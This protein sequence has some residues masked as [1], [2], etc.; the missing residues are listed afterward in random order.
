MIKFVGNTKKIFNWNNVIADLELQTPNFVGPSHSRE[1]KLPGLDEILDMWGNFPID[2]QKNGGEIGW[3]MFIPEQNFDKKLLD[4]FADFVGLT[5][6][7]GGWI[8]RL[9]PGM[10]VPLHW[11]VQD[12]ENDIKNKV[13]K[14]YHCHISPPE[15]GHVFFV[16]GVPFVQQDQ[17][18]VYKWN[19]RKLWHAGNN[20]GWKPKYLLNFW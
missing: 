7:N 5:E 20:V 9:N 16:E 4:D 10:I 15:W 11:D 1:D 8:S 18:N 13:F 17:G 2:Y 3:D 14:R 19:S 6:Y 12:N